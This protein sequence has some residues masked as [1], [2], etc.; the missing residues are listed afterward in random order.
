MSTL[1]QANYDRPTRSD[2]AVLM[3]LFNPCGSLRLVNNWLY[4]W[5]KLKAADIPV[6]GAELLFPWQNPALSDAVKTLTVRSDS[7][8]FHKE[9]LLARLE[10]EVP[11]TYTKLCCIDCDIVFGR[12]DWYDAVSDEL[13]RFPV[14]QP[15]GRCQWMGPDLRTVIMGNPGA[16]SQMDEIRSAHLMGQTDRLSGH[17][18]FAMAMRRDVQQF[19]WAVVGGGDAVFLRGVAGLIGEF[20][21]KRMSALTQAAW[22]EWS[23][24]A[25]A[26]MSFV[27]GD[28]F[29]LWHGP[30]KGRQYYD[31]YAK[32]VE[33][34]PASVGDIRDL[35]VENE[36]GVWAWREDVKKALNTMML[37]YFMG[38]DDDAVA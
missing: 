6:F 1:R 30:L 31:R 8:M 17:P 20:S 29:H 19:P 16:V 14:V 4:T 2:M 25:A 21:H 7:V 35:L 22:L 10:R 23:S 28:I 26:D 5:N 33:A 13:D 36:D 34:I 37:R 24:K 3:V 38:R 12:S 32:F 9:K 27:D 11:A 15:Y 18:G